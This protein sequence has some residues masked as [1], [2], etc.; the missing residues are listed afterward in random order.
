[1]STDFPDVSPA[2]PIH[3]PQQPNE[4]FTEPSSGADVPNHHASAEAPAVD[5]APPDEGF[6]LG[7]NRK[8]GGP[9]QLTKKDLDQLR[10]LYGGI[11]IGLMPFNEEAAVQCADKADKCVDAWEALAKQ[12]DNVRRALLAILEGGAWGV[13]ISAHMPIMMA[14]VP[15]H[16][17]ERMPML[18]GITPDDD[19]DQPE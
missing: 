11:S 10:E 4:W 9:R 7:E 14:F 19:E 5:T 3:T 13:V 6:K 17:K 8:R 18:F 12:N 1:M 15:R 2:P 16:V